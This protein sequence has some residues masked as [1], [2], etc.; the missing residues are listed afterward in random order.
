MQKELTCVPLRDK[1]ATRLFADA[2]RTAPN[3]E[4]SIDGLSRDMIR[5]LKRQGYTLCKVTT[6]P[7][8]KKGKT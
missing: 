6:R 5:V 7:L 2:F 3:G 1:T 4:G 8:K